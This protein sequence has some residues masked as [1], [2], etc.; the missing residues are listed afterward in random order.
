V[1][2]LR[3]LEEAGVLD[4]PLPPPA[5]C[6]RCLRPLEVDKRHW[7][8]CYACGHEHPHTLPRIAALTYGAAGC[9]RR[10]ERRGISKSQSCRSRDS[11][12]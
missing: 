9:R 11:P 5:A 10:V 3:H 2:G 7:D 12:R 8:T 6:S 1:N 4:P